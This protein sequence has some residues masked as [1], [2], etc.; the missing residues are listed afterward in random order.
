MPKWTA[1]LVEQAAIEFVKV[2]GE[3][4]T[5]YDLVEMG[6]SEY[7][8]KRFFKK[9]SNLHKKIAPKVQDYIGNTSYLP[10]TKRPLPI[11]EKGI[12][13]ITSHQNNTSY[14][15]KFYA[16]LLNLKDHLK[17]KLIIL[18]TVYHTR[19]AEGGKYRGTKIEVDKNTQKIKKTRVYTPPKWSEELNPFY[20]STP[21]K[22]NEN[23]EV[24]A[25]V[26]IEATAHNPLSGMER[27]TGVASAI[28]G[29]AQ[30]RWQYVATP[31][32]EFAKV[33]MTTGS[34]SNRNYTKTKAGVKGA[35]HH[36]VGALVVYVENDKFWPF[37]IE[38]DNTGGFYHLTHRYYPDGYDKVNEP[39]GLVLGDLH[40]E[41][42]DPRVQE[43][44]W[45]AKNSIVKTLPVTQQVWH[46]VIDFNAAQSHHN[47]NDWIYRAALEK[48]G[49]HTAEWSLK[50]TADVIKNLMDSSVYT[51]EF[52]IVSSNHQDHVYRW[53]N[54]A[55]RSEMHIADRMLFHSLCDQIYKEVSIDKTNK[56][57]GRDPFQI[58]IETYLPGDYSKSIKWVGRNSAYKINGNDCSQHG[59]RGP[60]GTRGSAEALS[61][62]SVKNIIGHSH[63][64]GIV[65]DT[66]QV[67]HSAYDKRNYNSGY[68]SWAH[69][70]CLIYPNGTRTLVSI[71]DGRWRPFTHA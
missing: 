65:F 12:Y 56:L 27:L 2:Y 41:W 26:N 43:A 53:I 4:P 54:E 36:K 57:C 20:Q 15:K 7:P 71:I 1:E 42:M 38:A 5:T 51:T 28:F 59:D 23:L 40:C 37:S 31:P 34:I 58:Y 70:H 66:Y 33:M 49:K 61:A 6:M 60:N 48:A 24:C 25:G 47:K 3:Y 45:T 44:T 63:T 10:Q 68:S 16:S 52:A 30:V 8:I 39:L 32:T 11:G 62:S 17:A 13:I 22:L 18:P 29:H 9:L 35:M 64:P 67:G 19:L 21:I 14:N 55:K 69:V 50:T 46:D